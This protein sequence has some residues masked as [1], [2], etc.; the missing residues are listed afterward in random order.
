[1]KVNGLCRITTDIELKTVGSNQIAEFGIAWKDGFK[2]DVSHFAYCVAFGKQA[3]VIAQYLGKGLRVSIAGDLV[4]NSWT[5]QDGS[6]KSVL[7]ININSFEFV[8]SKDK[9]ENNQ[10]QEPINK[11]DPFDED[12]PF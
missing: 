6:K 8:D 5:A 4:Q 10:N 9:Q 1:M 11:Q 7:K 2:K 3:E 12:V